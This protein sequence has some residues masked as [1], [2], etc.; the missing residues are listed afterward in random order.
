MTAAGNY[1]PSALRLPFSRIWFRGA[2][3]ED[4]KNSRKVALQA[5]NSAW[6]YRVDINQR[7]ASWCLIP[8]TWL[9]TIHSSSCQFD[10][11]CIWYLFFLSD[12]FIFD[13]TSKRKDY[14]SVNCLI[15][16]LGKIFK[17]EFILQVKLDNSRNF[18]GLFEEKL[19]LE[20]CV[21]KSSIERESQRRD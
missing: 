12:W 17:E 21:T 4:H 15:F 16:S 18:T 11:I 14:T 3:D 7:S 2:L 8:I 19:S 6:L 20:L 9:V 1:A 10:Y 13:Y 5:E